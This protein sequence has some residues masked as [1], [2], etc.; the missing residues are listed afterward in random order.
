MTASQILPL[1]PAEG[2]EHV[3]DLRADQTRALLDAVMGLS[4]D[5]D[6]HSVLARLVSAAT[7]LTGAQYGALGVIGAD[8]DLSDFITTG[9]DEETRAAIGAEPRGR[10]LLGLLVHDPR[11]LRLDDLH[12]HPSAGGMPANH[13][14]MTTFLG[15]PIRIRGTVFGNLY[16]TEKSNGAKFTTEDELMVQ[17]LAGAAGLV[18]ENARAY[19]LSE[20]SRQW[21][22]ASAQLAD[23]LQPPILLSTALEMVA[24]RARTAA[25]A[26][27]AAVVQF[28]VD[29]PPV[30]SAVDGSTGPDLAP[31]LRG[32]VGEARSA[33]ELA[34]V[35]EVDLGQQLALVIPLR[36]HLADP[37]VLVVIF[38]RGSAAARFEEREFL[39]S[40]ADQ[41]GLAIDRAQAVADR[42][43]LAVVSE[44]ARI[45]RDLH[46]VVIQ[47]LFAAGLKL[48]GIVRSP[49]A[50]ASAKVI[51]SSVND[52]D[53]TIRDIRATIFG[54]QQPEHSLRGQVHLIIREYAQVLG[55]EP[56][57]STHGA[58]DLNITP[59][60]GR[61]LLA[62]LRE[63]LSNVAR[64][65]HAASAAVE[66]VA[67]SGNVTLIVSDTGVG[68][69]VDRVE[70]GLRN[71]RDRAAL[72]GGSVQIEPNQG[73]GTTL[74]W[75]VPL[76]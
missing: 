6:L 50:V 37:G 47:R 8:G 28:P 10:G 32:V 56:S 74:T 13:P 14:E 5:L 76:V 38:D 75:T 30:I 51:E 41:A 66:V 20:R 40:F 49:G 24:T 46:D 60:V 19:G 21:L 23:A 73:P 55:F 70:S 22:E 64:H 31:T 43:E 67:A 11:T 68:I 57:L 65:A 34:F 44:R 4:S 62:V 33:D 35:V 2:S 27:T 9:I 69:S 58:L 42:E 53:A 63:A 26:A 25:R 59:L 72:L 1:P 52:L 36:A 71:V 17:A 45:A 7:T 15:V 48:Q 3:R 12:V 54:L 29:G 39:A 16:L 61:H 18:I